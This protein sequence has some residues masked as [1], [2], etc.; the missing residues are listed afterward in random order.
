MKKHEDGGILSAQQG[1]KISSVGVNPKEGT[2][3]T[4]AF[5]KI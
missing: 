5:P 3:R 2:W 1:T 4:L